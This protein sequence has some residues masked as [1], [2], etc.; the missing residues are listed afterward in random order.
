MTKIAI[1]INVNM[2]YKRLMDLIR[3]KANRSAL[4]VLYVLLIT[5]MFS[6][7]DRYLQAITAQDMQIDQHWGNGKGEGYQEDLLV[8]CF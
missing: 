7:V 4:F 6:Q 8:M 1:L 5:Y 3:D 2:M